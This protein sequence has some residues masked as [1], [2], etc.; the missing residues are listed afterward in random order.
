MQQ[1]SFTVSVGDRSM[2]RVQ[3][4]MAAYQ[5]AEQTAKAMA[6]AGE[7]MVAQARKSMD[8][9]LGAICDSHN[10]SLPEQYSISLRPGD[11]TITVTDMAPMAAEP[12]L[13][14]PP[15]PGEAEAN[16]NGNL[17]AVE[18]LADATPMPL[19]AEDGS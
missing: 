10:E 12:A 13:P 17:H 2:R 3:I 16:R 8:E 5:A 7:G 1:Q 4:A 19:K 6:Q 18:A 14:G 9:A 11:G 15:P